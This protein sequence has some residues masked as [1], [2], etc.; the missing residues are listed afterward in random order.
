MTISCPVDTPVTTTTSRATNS[1]FSFGLGYCTVFN[2][3]GSQ[4]IFC[5]VVLLLLTVLFKEEVLADDE[6]I[7]AWL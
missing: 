1:V 3:I 6:I 2:V 7:G 5:V 4:M